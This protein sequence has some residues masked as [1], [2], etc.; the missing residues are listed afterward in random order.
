MTRYP[1]P[2]GITRVIETWFAS[3]LMRTVNEH[4]EAVSGAFH[5]I[6]CPRESI[7]V[8]AVALHRNTSG[9]PSGSPA[10]AVAVRVSPGAALGGTSWIAFIVGGRFWG[11]TVFPLL[12]QPVSSRLAESATNAATSTGRSFG[13]SCLEGRKKKPD[14]PKLVAYLI[15]LSRV[16]SSFLPCVTKRASHC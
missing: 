10:T 8:P 15:L 13:R 14:F 7:N 4:V 1:A 12:E 9:L 5:R 11:A 16:G 2:T 6:D 3:S